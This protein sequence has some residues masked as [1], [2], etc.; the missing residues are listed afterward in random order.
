VHEVVAEPFLG[1]AA[2]PLLLR[3]IEA[4]VDE[5]L[6]RDLADA[7]VAELLQDVLAHVDGEVLLVGPQTPDGETRR[8]DLDGLEH[9]RHPRGPPQRFV[10]EAFAFEVGAQRLERGQPSVVRLSRVRGQ[11]RPERGPLGEAR[12]QSL[13]R[14]GEVL[15]PTVAWLV[16][17][18]GAHADPIGLWQAS[19]EATDRVDESPSDVR[20]LALP[21]G[22]RARLDCR[23]QVPIPG[24][25]ELEQELSDAVAVERDDQ[26]GQEG[27]VIAVLV[28]LAEDHD[29]RRGH[30]RQERLGQR[31]VGEG[32]D[33]PVD[34]C[35]EFVATDLRG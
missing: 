12:R 7:P 28:Q 31:L 6:A 27:V 4:D 13:E 9:D 10:A 23:D 11:P 1:R 8:L 5:R 19:V 26:G 21:T 34:D 25:R 18:D 22:H 16:G 17:V 14:G 32:D 24:V 30:A 15:C 33:V 2:Q 29:A 20:V 3:M 35:C